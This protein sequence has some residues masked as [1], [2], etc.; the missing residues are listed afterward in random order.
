MPLPLYFIMEFFH[1]TDVGQIVAKQQRLSSAHAIAITAHVCDALQYA[2]ER[3]VVHR[4]I[5]PANIMVGYDGRVK[6]A[7]FGLVK[8]E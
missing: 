5:K 1:G 7:D 8:T 6:V 2:H 4:D 3:G